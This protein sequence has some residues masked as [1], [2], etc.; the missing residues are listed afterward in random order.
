MKKKIFITGGKGMLA[1]AIEAFYVQQG[2]SVFAPTHDELDVC[3]FPGLKDALQSF[4][5]DLVF[6]TAAVHVDACESS[7]E[8][9]FQL[10][11]WA[12]KNI[13]SLCAANDA[14]LVSISTGGLFGDEIKYYTEYDPVKLKTTY[15]VSKYQG[16]LLSLAECKKTYI[17]RPGWLFGGDTEQKKNFVFQRYLDAKK[18]T[19]I[20]SANDKFGSPTFVDDLAAKID[21]IVQTEFPGTYHVSNAGGCSRYEYI[22][23]IIECF[24]LKTEVIAVA[25]SE[26]PRKANVPDC[27]MLNNL[28]MKF[29][30]VE[31]L[32]AWE[33]AIERCVHTI[34]RTLNNA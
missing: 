19:S 16:E 26:F 29:I 18:S 7:P 32:P 24:K 2:D 30:G 11:S 27:E 33:D 15:A 31:P 8:R 17:I 28:N 20:K 14:T 10:N 1:S 21:D 6:H 13:A 12:S 25:S 4:K 34:K 9:A 22:K 23:K 5:P 3:D